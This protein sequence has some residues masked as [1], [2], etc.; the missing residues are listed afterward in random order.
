[1]L[2][3]A[4]YFVYFLNIKMSVYS[5]KHHKHLIIVRVPK[6]IIF[7]LHIYKEKDGKNNVIYFQ[8]A[9]CCGS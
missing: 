8:D 6:L 2:H 7:L 3:K 5:S 1:M 4:I 9:D